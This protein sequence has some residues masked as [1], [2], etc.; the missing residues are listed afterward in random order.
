MPCEIEKFNNTADLCNVEES[1]SNIR[2]KHV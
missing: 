1:L 2:V